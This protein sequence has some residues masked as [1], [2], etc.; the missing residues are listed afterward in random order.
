[1]KFQNEGDHSKV[2]RWQVI[3]GTTSATRLD[4]ASRAPRSRA[5]RDWYSIPSQ[6]ENR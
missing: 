5:V 6:G 2:L 3:N 4:F 1:M